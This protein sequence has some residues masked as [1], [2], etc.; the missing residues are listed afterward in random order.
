MMRSR[1]AALVA[2]GKRDTIHIRV[3]PLT[4][5][6]QRRPRCTPPAA[7]V[8]DVNL[9]S[10]MR[11]APAGI[12]VT[13]EPPKILAIP[14]LPVLRIR[15]IDVQRDVPSGL[16]HPALLSG[17]VLTPLISLIE[18]T[19]DRSAGCTP[20]G[21]VADSV[22]F[23]IRPLIVRPRDPGPYT[24]RTTR[25]AGADLGF[26]NQFFATAVPAAGWRRYKP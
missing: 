14:M 17:L 23:D 21:F 11:V 5:G 20:C 15:R 26:R 22:H 24:I 13:L 25:A 12:A 4:T 2:C 18:S 10:R 19:S 7:S 8:Q 3:K 1:P 9:D 6:Y 16:P